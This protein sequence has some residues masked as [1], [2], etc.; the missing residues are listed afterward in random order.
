MKYL[1]IFLITLLNILQCYSQ[2]IEI[3]DKTS[4]TI[5]HISDEEMRGFFVIHKKIN[6]ADLTYIATLKVKGNE[7]KTSRLDILFKKLQEKAIKLSANSFKHINSKVHPSIPDSNYIIVKIFQVERNI[8][9]NSLQFFPENKIYIFGNLNLSAKKARK[10]KVNDRKLFA[11]P[12]KYIA[13]QNKVGLETTISVGGITGM[14]IW[15]KGKEKREPVFY[16]FSSFGIGAGTPNPNVIG[17]G[18]NTG[19]IY[20]VDFNFGNLLLDILP[21]QVSM[22]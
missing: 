7:I 9:A 1:F 11:E 17:G 13:Y 5:S 4:N 2:N 21:Q 22:R 15:V 10:I 3:L 19:R 8:L 6:E 14:K 20:R 16:S 18:I 12:L